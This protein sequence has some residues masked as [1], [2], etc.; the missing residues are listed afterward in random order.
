MN[1]GVISNCQ[2]YGLVNCLSILTRDCTLTGAPIIRAKDEKDRFSDCDIIYVSPEFEDRAAEALG[3]EMAKRFKPLPTVFFDRFH[4]DL[5][6]LKLNGNSFAG[7]LDNY[8]SLIC[9]GAYKAGRSVDETV[10]LYNAETYNVLDY[11]SGWKEA[12]DTFVKTYADVG[13]E[14][15]EAFVEWSRHAPFMHTFNHPKIGCLFDIAKAALIRD[16]IP[17]YD[18]RDC[19]VH[20]NLVQG[21]GFPVYTEIAE[22]YGLHGNYYFK[23]FHQYRTIGLREFVTAS[24]EI[25]KEADMDGAEV[26][27][28]RTSEY[29]KL[30]EALKN[31]RL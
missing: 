29:A 23:L 15:G 22:R 10:A 8:H 14:I 24:Y 4:P 9:F 5:T 26:T 16:G 20:D 28:L 13:L 18:Y 19:R 2:V 27:A 11:M 7:V 6:Y 3:E 12:A 30:M 31:G 25:Y 17:H 1:I 21:V